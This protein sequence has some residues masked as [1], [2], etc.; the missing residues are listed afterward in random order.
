MHTRSANQFI[1]AEVVEEVVLLNIQ[2]V[3]ITQQPCHT[4]VIILM[5]R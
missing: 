4:T 1:E 2:S 5:Y 3:M